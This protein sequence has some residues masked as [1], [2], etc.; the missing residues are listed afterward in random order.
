MNVSYGVKAGYQT[1]CD[2]RLSSGYQLW[3][4]IVIV[5]L[6]QTGR[7]SAPGRYTRGEGN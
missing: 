5:V 7:T 4:L 3:G 2:N 6:R 1:K